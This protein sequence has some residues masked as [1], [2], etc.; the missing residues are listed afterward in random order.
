MSTF[1]KNFYTLCLAK[2]Q[3]R[4]CQE[5]HI[6]NSQVKSI[7]GTVY[8]CIFVFQSRFC[9]YFSQLMKAGNVFHLLAPH[10]GAET[11]QTFLFFSVV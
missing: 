7:Y 4:V 8:F 10:M 11:L 3:T 1:L 5:K 6:S 2:L 9:L